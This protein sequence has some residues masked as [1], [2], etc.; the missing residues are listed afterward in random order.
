MNEQAFGIPSHGEPSHSPHR[1]P[2]RYL[3]VIDG[4]GTALAKLFL[5]SHEQVGEYLGGSE[6]V[7]TMTAGLVPENGA[8]GGAW[9]VALASHSDVERAAAQVYT[10]VV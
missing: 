5:A 8:A 6:E 7:A 10:L 2:A 4:D 9:A 1:P 3:V